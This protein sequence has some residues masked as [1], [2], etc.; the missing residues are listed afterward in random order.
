LDKAYY[1]K[2]CNYALQNNLELAIDNL[3]KAIE[4]VPQKYQNLAKTD[5]DFDKIR[6]EK[7]FQE[8]LQ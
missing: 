7:Q 5:P 8:L 1:N 2:A 6:G 3:K 4:F